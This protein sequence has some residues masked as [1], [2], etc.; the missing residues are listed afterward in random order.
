[1]RYS[2][3]PVPNDDGPV[4]VIVPALP[5]CVSMGD[6]HTDAL[7]HTR[8]AIQG[9][10][11]SEATAG[12]SPPIETPTVVAASI[13]ETLAIIDEMRAA[14]EYPPGPGYQFEVALLS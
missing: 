2:A 12:K 7:E 5:G 4:S 9:W 11:E 14:G 3:F 1:M 13:A 8:A 6:T 10:L